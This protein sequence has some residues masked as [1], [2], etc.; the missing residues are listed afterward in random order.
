MSFSAQVGVFKMVNP[1]IGP[2]WIMHDI[3]EIK[4][5][6]FSAMRSLENEYDSLRVDD[7]KKKATTDPM[8]KYVKR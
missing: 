4:P 5:S 1:G 6:S 2:G 8:F 7:V 3:S